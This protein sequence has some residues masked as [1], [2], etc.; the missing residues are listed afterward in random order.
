VYGI[1]EEWPKCFSG[2]NTT[3]W[4]MDKKMK[5]QKEYMTCPNFIVSNEK[6]RF[7]SNILLLGTILF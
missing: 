2:N 5:A 1:I 6:P 7:M 4:F 3:S